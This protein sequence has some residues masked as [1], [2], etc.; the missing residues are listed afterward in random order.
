MVSAMF[1]TVTYLTAG[2]AC[3]F[4]WS[5]IFAERLA[6]FFPL[7]TSSWVQGIPV[8][9]W[10]FIIAVITVWAVL[11]LH[12]NDLEWKM[13]TWGCFS[14]WNSTGNISFSYL[15]DTTKFFRCTNK[16]SCSLFQIFFLL[17]CI[18]LFLCL[19]ENTQKHKVCCL[20]L[21]C[22]CKKL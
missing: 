17:K 14:K 18:W 11:K 1:L 7:V 10:T 15:F 4:H 22:S 20:A 3:L 19:Q 12:L 13:L 9:W 8:S 6:S 2:T 16:F 5:F 21:L